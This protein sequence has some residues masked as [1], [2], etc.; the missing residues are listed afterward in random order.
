MT[1]RYKLFTFRNGLGE[2]VYQIKWRPLWWIEATWSWSGY[3]WIGFIYNLDEIPIQYL[4]REDALIAITSHADE[5]REKLAS[6]ISAEQ[7]NKL[8][9]IV[10]ESIDA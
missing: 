7:R 3:R 9:L 4:T 6:E 5:R 1:F 2:T 10:E 8:T